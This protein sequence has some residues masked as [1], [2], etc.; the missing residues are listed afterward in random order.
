MM[1][2]L[3]PGALCHA[4]PC[5]ASACS[6]WLSALATFGCFSQCQVPTPAPT[7][8]TYPLASLS[9]SSATLKL[10]KKK[11]ERSEKREAKKCIDWRVLLKEETV[12][13]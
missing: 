4:M 1:K 8:A 6:A 10:P 9:H 5:H 11:R 3:V 13:A 12:A 7:P 2:C